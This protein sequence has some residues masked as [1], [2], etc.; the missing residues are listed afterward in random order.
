MNKQ[1]NRTNFKMGVFG[2][3]FNPLHLGH[4][5]LLIQVQ[6]QFEFDLIKVV[7]AWQNPLV[8]PPCEVSPEKRLA[9][10]RKV[11][12]EYPFIEVDDQ[13][14]KRG[15]LSYTINTIDALANEDPI[16]KDIFLIMGIDQLVHFDKWKNFES[17]IK[18]VH[19]VVCSRKGYEW[20]NLII[21][22]LLK[23]SILSFPRS[24]QEVKSSSTHHPVLSKTAV[25]LKTGMSIHWLPLNNMDVSS[26]YIR[27]RIKQKLSV[28][29]LVPPSVNQWIQKRNLYQEVLSSVKKA[30]SFH[31][32]RYCINILIDKKGEK[33][34]TFDLRKVSSFP[35][36]FVLIVSGL[37]TRHTKM[38]ASYLHSQVKKEFP[39]CAQQME[40]QEN[41][42][43][44]VLDYGEL[45]VHIFYDY[46]RDYYHLEDFY[47]EQ[48][49]K[50]NQDVKKFI[51]Q[52]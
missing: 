49:Q 41:G 43:W 35:F 40:G 42:E 23:K 5:N 37:N 34:K 9:I 7:P 32:M 39:F 45:V 17:I 2:A 24:S 52:K 25:K 15:G 48:I 47:Q 18:R 38:L 20:N 36:N 14:I 12:K 27:Q 51:I 33:I 6:E 26:S 31:L 21:P 22:P 19:L 3:S 16:N 8:F 44:I 4:L 30:D 46:T 10:V 11:F 28:N 13:E 29:H 1:L 50:G